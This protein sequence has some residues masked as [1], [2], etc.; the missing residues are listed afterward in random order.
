MP[1]AATLDDL[2]QAGAAVVAPTAV[3]RLYAEAFRRFGAQA[4][5]SRTPSAAPT[6]GQAVVVAEALRREG[7]MAAWQLAA[8]IEA[9]CRA[10]I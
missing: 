3:G 4:L 7:N 6:V 5:W 1:D 9:A 10:A 2:K 8:D